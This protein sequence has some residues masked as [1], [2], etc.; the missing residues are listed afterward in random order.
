MHAAQS[1]VR[2]VWRYRWKHQTNRAGKEEEASI[3]SW[4]GRLPRGRYV[5]R[6]GREQVERG[7]M[8][9]AITILERQVAAGSQ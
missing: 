4:N 7:R 3:L 1:P 2:G 8:A 6:G 5:G 9:G